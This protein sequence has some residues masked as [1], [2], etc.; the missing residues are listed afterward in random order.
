MSETMN[1]DDLLLSGDPLLAGLLASQPPRIQAAEAEAF[2]RETYGI[3]ARAKEIACERDQN[4]HMVAGDGRAFALKISN[5]QESPENTNFQTEALR[6]LERTDP[7]LPVPKM[8][9]ARDGRFEVTLALPDGRTS[10]VRVLTWVEGEPLYRVGVGPEME[11]RIG[12]ILARLGRA[13]HDFT[14]PGARHEILW[15]IRNAPRL[16]PLLS[17]LAGDALEQAVRTEL[18]AYESGVLPRLTELR[19]QVVHNDLNH[20]NLV[21]DPDR[22]GEISGVLDFGDMVDTQLAID[23][24]VAA[25]YLAHHDDPLTSVARMVGA[26][27]AVTPLLPEEIAVLRDLIVARLVTSITITGWRARRYPENAAYILRNNGPARLAMQRF[28]TLDPSTVTDRL[29]R[30]CELE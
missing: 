7:T 17:A 29:L 8:V 21:V 30:A 16:R 4:F 27:H 23:V 24:A 14:H 12:A 13:L 26:Y 3:A 18:D 15:D 19:H 6:W 10:V 25:S 9:A 11:R 22:P 28:A 5:P 1:R 2:L 20:H